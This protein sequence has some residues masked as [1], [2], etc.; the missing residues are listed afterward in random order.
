[1]KRLHKFET[2]ALLALSAIAVS[3]CRVQEAVASQPATSPKLIS[4]N[5]AKGVQ[6]EPESVKLAGITLVTA[7]DAK[8]SATLQPTGEVSATDDGMVQL[9]SRLPGK[10]TAALVNVGDHVHKGQVVAYVDSVDLAQAQATYQTAV[11]HETLSK[12]QLEQQKKLAGYGSLSEQ[13][14]EDAKRASAASDAAVLS[15]EAQIRVDQLALDSTKKLV[16]MG[17]VTRKPVEDAQNAYAQ[18]VAA[19]DQARANL[20]S[21]RAN[22]DRA[23]LLY[24]GGVFAR[25]QFEDADTAYK[26]AVAGMK[27]AQTGEALAKEE[28]TRQQTIYKQDL[29][30]ATSLQGAEAKLQQDQHTYQNDLV[31]QALSH[32][33]YARALNVVKSG[34]PVSQA[35]QQAQDTYDEA[36]IAEQSASSTLKMYGVN[37]RSL[38]P[39]GSAVVPLISPIDGIVAARSMVVGQNTD[40]GTVLARV[41]NLDQVYVDAQVYEKDAQGVSVG[42]S[43]QV[44]VSALPDKTFTGKVKWVANEINPDTRTLTVRTVL[45]NPKWLLRPGMF[46]S[47]LVGSRQSIRAIAIPS[48]A[49]LRE[50][51]EQ[52][53]YVQVAPGQFVKRQV[54]TRP[55]IG[56][57][58]PISAG[59]SV[60]DQ[61]VVG[62]NVLIQKEQEQLETGKAEDK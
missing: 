16:A 29:N 60:G 56:G 54:K 31:S 8:L 44:H 3:G 50:G 2:Y 21:A 26:S 42:D 30:G 28:L 45:D 6:L 11:A 58:V 19:A 1:M 46:A 49:V 33:E 35:L 10:I 55:A 20:H 5:G 12:N 25:Q 62:G 14:V 15:D 9:T 27:Q 59:L 32:K 23:K 51:E 57:Q 52:V 24:E 13:P 48:D 41:A 53:V 39:G 18:A 4:V 22:F 40:T 37:P 38:S 61:V 36:V 47:V 7:G 17:E 43:V 34:I